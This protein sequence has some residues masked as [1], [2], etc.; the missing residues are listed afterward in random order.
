M[1]D[2]LNPK[3]GLFFLAFLP[4][5]VSTNAQ[6]PFLE[7]I[8]FGCLFVAVGGVVNLVYAL[9]AVKSS[10]YAGKAT[11]KWLQKWIPGGVLVGLGI[12][13]VVLEE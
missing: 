10:Q 5:F 2:L 12:R 8:Y 11:R 1:V 13:L 3:I 9:T 7:T 4:Q 6:S